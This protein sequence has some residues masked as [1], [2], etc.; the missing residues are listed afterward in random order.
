MEGKSQPA[1]QARS[2]DVVERALT[3]RMLRG[4]TG[5]R[6]FSL[7]LWPIFWVVYG[8]DA[9]W[10]MIV[11]PG[12]LHVVAVVGFIALSRLYPHH[13]L[14]YTPQRWVTFYSAIACINGIS[15]GGGGAL[16]V[17]LPMVEPRLVVC[18]ILAVAAEIA[19]GR[20][21][22]PRAFFSF[23]A[24]N[25]GLLAL[26]LVIE[27]SNIS[28]AVAGATG[29]YLAALWLLNRPQHRA[30]RQQIHD[31]VAN[32]DLS[33]RLDQALTDSQRV[34]GTLRTVLD[35]MHDGIALYD[36]EGNWL[37]YNP[38]FC[39]LLDLDEATM[40]ANRNVR[41]LIRFQVSRGD[42]GVVAEADI[43]ADVERRQ[44]IITQATGTAFARRGR[45]GLTLE[46][47]SHRL[48]DG[49][50]LATYRD[51]T[52][53]KGSEERFSLVAAASSEGIYDWDIAADRLYISPQIDS[54]FDLRD[55]ESSSHKWLSRVHPE[56]QAPYLQNLRDH[57]AGRSER[58]DAEYRL[59]ARDGSWRW[60]RDRAL[61]V[62]DVDG[63]AVRMVGAVTDT[64]P[65]MERDAA[66]AAAR[67]QAL[68]ANQRLIDAI[69]SIPN[70]FLLFDKDE[71]LVLSNKRFAGFYPAIADIMQPGL[72]VSDMLRT[73]AQAN[74]VH[75]NGRT[76]E[77]FV[78]WRM[79]QRRNPG[80]PTETQLVDGK[81]ISIGERRTSDGGL[82]G[83]Y[84]D[85]TDLKQRQAELDRARGEAEA[86]NRAKST[87]LAVMSHE[88][89]TPMNGVLGMMDVLETQ[90]LTQQQR[91][92]LGTMRESARSL[93]RIIEGVLDFS[94][95]EAGALELE[96]APF[97]LSELVGGAIATFRPQAESKGLT[98]T[99]FVAPDSA[100]ALVGDPTR[101]RQILF[102]LLANALKFTDKGGARLDVRTEPLG[103]G[104]TRVVM[105]VADTGIGLSDEQQARLFQP[106]AQA[107]SSTTRRF[108]G[109]GLGLSIVRRLA[110][111]M[112]GDVT[113]ESTAGKGATFNV[114]LE[115]KAAPANSPIVD[116]PRNAAGP[117]KG[118]PQRRKLIGGR[119]LVV[120]D[121]PI[122]RDVL[123]GQLRVLG[124]AAD[125]A[126]D[127]KRGYEAWRDGDYAVV[128]ADIHMP[129]M[130]G[131]EMTARIRGDEKDA[132]KKRTPIVAVTANAMA[133]E[134]ERCRAGGMDAYLSKPVSLDRLRAV[135]ERWFKSE[136][137][138]APVIDRS[139]LDP[140]VEDDEAE[141]RSLLKRFALSTEGARRDIEAA[142]ADNNLAA[143]A[144]EAHKL[145]GSA[146]AVGARAVGDAAAILERA[147]KAG[148]RAACQDG[149]GP[150]AVEVQR[151]QAEIGV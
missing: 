44:A 10:W 80:P 142:M 24:V 138:E 78:E 103:E 122:N 105:A 55:D 135:L 1:A 45:N 136:T 124:V 93:L 37:F 143:L 101:V 28:L 79:A 119:V 42:F 87:F 50:L 5:L 94:K 32:A 38:A 75:L 131:F 84:S 127:G 59:Q 65:I 70:G 148:D 110:I 88:I 118:K 115:L 63:R 15:Y 12:L 120:D 56:D 34:R 35:N 30:Q 57:L 39:T 144:A 113:V 111:A 22:S 151:A 83:I 134:D 49:R 150:L 90:G 74:S 20:L 96:E 121:H 108:G 43:D 52:E 41:D 85:I 27:G 137:P 106:F 26:G 100:D 116:L 130:D 125:T 46:V 98:L 33:E 77:E 47:Q 2:E 67:D 17:M 48:N 72:H 114:K 145:K 102:N 60:M 21:Y 69:E 91:D 6:L 107:D 29:V 76:V 97:S 18:A 7:L 51:I 61:A 62:R 19:P 23:A 140:W 128:F 112:G 53:L 117:A 82:V 81:W 133:G 147:A 86:A 13:R 71:K 8:G 95:I 129:V 16:L 4:N 126:A 132:G 64:T 11:F 66:L 146:L 92:S 36:A 14:K 73:N 141:R 99:S 68:R 89:R 139:V 54:L 104:R 58:L 149:L 31:T 9:P 3:D 123:V 109:T 25:L 40:Q